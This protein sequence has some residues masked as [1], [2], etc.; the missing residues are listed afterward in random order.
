MTE[1]VYHTGFLALDRGADPDLDKRAT[2]LL[3]RAEAGQL[4][5]YQHRL[6][7]GYLAKVKT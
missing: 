1:T 3:Q 5:L 4:V 6:S 7:A 2:D